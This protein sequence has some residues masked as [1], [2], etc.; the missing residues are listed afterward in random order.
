M[1]T[2]SGDKQLLLAVTMFPSVEKHLSELTDVA[3][4]PKYFFAKAT[5]NGYFDARVFHHS[6]AS[7]S[8]FNCGS[9]K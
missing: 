9:A 2:V 3:G 5:I 1:F 6:S 8:N 7:K 4:I